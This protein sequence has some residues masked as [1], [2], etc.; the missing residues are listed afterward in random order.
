[1]TTRSRETFRELVTLPDLGVP[2]A[3]AALLMA[4]EEYPQ[5]SLTPYLDQLDKMSGCVQL[6]T[7]PEASPMEI[8]EA[9]NQVLFV[10][11]G[12]QGNSKSYYDPRNSFLNEVIERRTGIPITLSAIYIEVARRFGFRIDGVGVPGHFLVK[13]TSPTEEIFVDPYNSGSILTR[14]D[15]QQLLLQT[16]ADRTLSDDYL[17]RRVTNRQIVMRILAN[18]K[19][20]YLNAQTF[21][22][23]VSILDLMLLTRPDAFDLYRERGLLQ[24]QLHKFDAAA[25]DLTRYLQHSPESA[26]HSNVKRYL[27]DISRIRAMRN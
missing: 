9:I 1:M 2:L 22:K 4:C 24:L 15:C 16:N 18:L 25:R 26:A 8:I 6:Q 5:L 14:K 12:F 3:E 10:D 17:L 21:D 11:Y 19:A 20:I 23:A 7:S 13:H 27:K